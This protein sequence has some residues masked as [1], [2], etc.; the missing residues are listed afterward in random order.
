MMNCRAVAGI[1]PG[2]FICCL[3][4]KNRLA[5]KFYNIRI[6]KYS[7]KRS[8]CREEQNRNRCDKINR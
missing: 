7:Q 2:R 1:I 4:I 6:E 8:G 5:C 3:T